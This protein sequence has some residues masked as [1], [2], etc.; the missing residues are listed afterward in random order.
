MPESLR[1]RI[2]AGP[3][4]SGKS[5]I[6]NSV[7]SNRDNGK[8][9]DFGIYINA[10]DIARDLRESSLAFSDYQIETSKRRFIHAALASGLINE[11]FS[12]E[13][14]ENCF[15]LRENR[16]F[17]EDREC[18]DRLAQIAA[19]VIRT[20]LLTLKK[21]FSFETVFS[22]ESKVAF[23]RRAAGQGYKVYLYFVCTEDPDINVYRVKEVRVKQG[24]HD[25]PEKSI[26]DRYYRS[27][28]QLHEAAQLTYR[29][30]FFDNSGENYKL[31]ADF[32][33]VSG[34]KKWN[35]SS[36]IVPQWFIDFYSNANN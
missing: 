13:R 23:M 5:T 36:E 12:H 17:L 28:K 34:R 25:V 22:H 27:L 26:R 8:P 19:D 3:N 4:G 24:G 35:V 6:I 11:G 15:S 32:K 33:Q 30:Y 16:L 7:R 18:V 20:E 9:V 31:F 29:S 21:K 14:F 1:L 2:F 10:D